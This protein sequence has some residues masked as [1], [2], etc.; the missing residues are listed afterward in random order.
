M[1]PQISQINADFLNLEARN[2]ILGTHVATAL[3]AVF[4]ADLQGETQV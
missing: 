1:H 3:W 4:P 2:N